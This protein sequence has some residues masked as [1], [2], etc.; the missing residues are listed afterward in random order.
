MVIT[1]TGF[2]TIAK[3]VAK[4]EGVADLRI[5]EY[6]GAVGVHPE[7]TV[8]KNVENVLFGRIIDHLTKPRDGGSG[9]A[10]VVT[11]KADDVVYEGSFD[12]VNEY[13]RQIGRAHV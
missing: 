1:T 10:P 3:A 7:E 8:V 11:R 2:T 4:A 13:F 12:D 9:T 5:G 6:P